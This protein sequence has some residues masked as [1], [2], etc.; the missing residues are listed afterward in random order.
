MNP[1]DGFNPAYMIDQSHNVTDPIESMLPAAETIGACFTKASLVD[2]DALHAA[3][4]A[5]RMSGYRARKAQERKAVGQ[6]AGIV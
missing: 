4:A 1:K 5:Y 3:Q 6:G 2:R